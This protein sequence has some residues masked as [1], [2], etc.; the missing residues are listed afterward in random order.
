MHVNPNLPV[1]PTLFFPPCPNV[2]SL[3]LCLY[4]WI[5]S[6]FNSKNGDCVD[7][8]IA[9]NSSLLSIKTPSKHPNSAFPTLLRITTTF[10][11]PGLASCPRSCLENCYIVFNHS[12]PPPTRCYW[13]PI[14]PPSRM[15]SSHQKKSHFPR[16]SGR[17]CHL[18]S[19]LLRQFGYNF[20]S[21]LSGLS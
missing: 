5:N 11:R 21:A 8:H 10:Q 17:L 15:C 1:H 7:P 16:G 19:I 3:P 6:S 12:P 9:L 18:A 13:I 14:G 2:C 20:E 4:F